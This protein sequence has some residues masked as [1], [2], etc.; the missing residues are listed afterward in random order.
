MRFEKRFGET[1]PSWISS[2]GSTPPSSRFEKR[3]GE[4][5]DRPL[6]LET[7]P[8]R[9]YRFTAPLEGPKPQ[10]VRTDL[11]LHKAMW[12][13]IAELRLAEERRTIRRYRVRTIL[14]AAAVLVGITL[15]AFFLTRG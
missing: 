11:S 1:R 15:M 4:D 5:A 9:G 2:R 8:K 14:V 7:I 12:L 10:L 6:Y 13:N 3:L